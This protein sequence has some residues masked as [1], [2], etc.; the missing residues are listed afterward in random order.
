MIKLTLPAP[1]TV[2][3][4]YRRNKGQG[5]HISPRGKQYRADVMQICA[6]ANVKPFTGRLA[7]KIGYAPP[8]RRKRDIDNIIKAVQDS[9]A[10]GGCM[11][12]DE[13]VDDLHVVRLPVE[14][15]GAAI[16]ELSEI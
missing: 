5:M 9:L 7:L 3:T 8:D 6:Q 12:D 15:F 11:L 1:P 13:Q 10:Y 4:Y 2:N 14:K 16:I